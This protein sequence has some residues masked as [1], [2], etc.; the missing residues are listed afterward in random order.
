MNYRPKYET[1]SL[2]TPKKNAKAVIYWTLAVSFLGL[3]PQPRETK[4]ETNCDYNKQKLL[5]SEGNHEQD[6]KVISQMDENVCK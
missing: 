6:K 3:S 1:G 2:K 5:L 4:A